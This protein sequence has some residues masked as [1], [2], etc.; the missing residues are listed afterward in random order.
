MQTGRSLAQLSSI[1]IGGTADLYYR[2]EKTDELEPLIKAAEQLKIPFIILGG[3][4]NTIFA[5]EGFRGLII[6]MMARRVA[7]EPSNDPAHGIISAEAGALMAQIIAFAL[8][9]NLSGLEKLM[10]LPGTIGG[11]V[12][13]NAGA[14]GTEIKDVFLKALIYSPG[15]GL[16][17]VGPEYLNFSYRKST[18]KATKDV[19][20]KVFLRLEAKDCTRA[21]AEATEI[22][23]NRITKQPKGQSTGSFFKNPGALLSAG[24]LLDRCGCKGLQVGG[25]QVSPEHA[26][27]IVNRGGATCKDV[28]DLAGMMRERVESR[29]DMTL[30]PEVQLIGP[31]GFIQL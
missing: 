7:L 31:T 19:I 26:N 21:V 11:A 14:Y 12:R 1:G 25:A 10:G 13:G 5:D 20:L 28:I 3:G 27:W 29:F 8:K 4:T 9:N 15:K 18:I 30:E 6:H 23:K 22:I 16:R 2:L 17:E 24:Y